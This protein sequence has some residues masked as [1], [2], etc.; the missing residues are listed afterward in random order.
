VSTRVELNRAALVE[1]A[2]DP[3]MVSVV[4]PVA[5]A[6]VQKA[7]S[8]SFLPRRSGHYGASLKST[9]A[10][11]SKAKLQATVGS[12]DPGAVAI[13]F[14]SVNNP[15]YAPITKAAKQLGLKIESAR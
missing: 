7:G 1:L 9:G 14:G 15:V 3:M 13:E 4:E 12:N 2:V 6:I 8:Y 10:Y 5:D 11:V